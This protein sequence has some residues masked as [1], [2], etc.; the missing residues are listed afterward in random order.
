MKRLVWYKNILEDIHSLNEIM[1]DIWALQHVC[2]FA[3]LS[4]GYGLERPETSNRFIIW[5]VSYLHYI[6]CLA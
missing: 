6:A 1:I 3:C 2:A 5:A 4:I